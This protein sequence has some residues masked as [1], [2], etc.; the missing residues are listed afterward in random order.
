[1]G[2]ISLAYGFGP[3]LIHIEVTGITSDRALRDLPVNALPLTEAFPSRPWALPTLFRWRLPT[4]AY[5]APTGI[6]TPTTSFVGKRAIRYTIEACAVPT[7]RRSPNGDGGCSLGRVN[8]S[9]SLPSWSPRVDLNHRPSSYQ[10]DAQTKLSYVESADLMCRSATYVSSLLSSQRSE[11]LQP[12][13][14][15][16]RPPPR[17]FDLRGYPPVPFPLPIRYHAGVEHHQIGYDHRSGRRTGTFAYSA[18]LIQ[19]RVPER[20]PKG[21]A[22]KTDSPERT[23]SRFRRGPAFGHQSGNEPG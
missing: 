15:A 17:G 2:S 12:V 14:F 19:F 22:N 10:E 18:S 21:N 13:S 3:Q 1:M 5:C 7:R 20:S 16:R 6:R 8:R 23:I 11:S 9:K 4:V